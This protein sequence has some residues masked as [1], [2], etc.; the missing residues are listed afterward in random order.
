METKINTSKKL[1]KSGGWTRTEEAFLLNNYKKMTDHVLGICLGRKKR[2]VLN[3]RTKLG[4]RKYSTE[5]YFFKCQQCD[6]EQRVSKSRSEQTPKFCSV[7]CR[8][9]FL[10]YKNSKVNICK[11][12]E[13]N[14]LQ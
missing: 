8:T 6:N 2:A 1:L 13:K 11:H 7:R 5:D 14:S 10:K 9:S 3:K 12:C 4:L